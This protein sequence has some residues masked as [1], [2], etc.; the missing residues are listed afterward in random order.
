MVEEGLVMNRRLILCARTRIILKT[1]L[2]LLG[3][4]SPERM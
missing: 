3:I 2:N 4:K 1:G